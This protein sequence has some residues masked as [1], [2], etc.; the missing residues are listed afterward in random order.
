MNHK[1]CHHFTAAECKRNVRKEYL[2]LTLATSSDQRGFEGNLDD[3]GGNMA[4]CQAPAAKA[5]IKF[6]TPEVEKKKD[7]QVN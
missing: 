2:A 5:N 1:S 7:Q 4:P 6:K 3:L